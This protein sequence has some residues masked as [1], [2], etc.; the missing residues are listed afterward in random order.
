MASKKT[1]Y[2]NED[3]RAR[4]CGAT[5]DI[6]FLVLILLLLLVGLT[7]LYSASFAQSE[8][9][10][11]YETSTKDLQKQAVCAGIGLIAMYLF[12]RIPSGVWYRFAWPMYGISIVLLLLVLVAGESVN[13]ARWWIN[14]AGI[15]FQPDVGTG[16]QYGIRRTGKIPEAE[17]A[18]FILLRR[19][20][21]F[22]Y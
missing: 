22:L 13:G 7:M 19:F 4:G 21:M 8:Y 20:N 11:G 17:E 10:T 15:Q 5:V 16:S 14:I 9:D 1:S 3:R 6:P 18:F 2:A 12:S